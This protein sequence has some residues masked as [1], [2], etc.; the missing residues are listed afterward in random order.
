MN[1]TC[2]MSL[3]LALFVNLSIDLSICLYCTVKFSTALH[4][5]VQYQKLRSAQDI[6]RG[7]NRR[8]RFYWG[9]EKLM[10]NWYG[11]KPKK[12]T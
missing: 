6:F 4:C 9:G 11:E 8:L 12:N 1:P 2:L 10:I 5:T 3:S 7:V